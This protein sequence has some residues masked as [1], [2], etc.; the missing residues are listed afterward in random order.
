MNTATISNWLQQPHNLTEQTEEELKVLLEKHPWFVPAHYLQA[1]QFI[2]PFS[3]ASLNKMKL[4]RGNWMFFHQMMKTVKGQGKAPT[5]MAKPTHDEVVEVKAEHIQE[6]ELI[7]PVFTSDYF[8]HQGVVTEDDVPQTM[9][10]KEEVSTKTEDPKTLMVV[11]SFQEWL[12]FF[13][14]KST[15]EKEEEEDKKAL[16]MR[17]Q[18]E[19]LAAALQEENEEIPENVFN[20]AVS[21]LNREE[22][23]ASESLAEILVKQGKNEAAIDMYHKLSLR[24]PTK[25]S[26]FAHQIEILQKGI[27]E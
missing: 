14:Q 11:M 20:M 16:K 9:D 26:Y 4:Y 3:P 25:R 6:A 8:R 21:S 23:L 24:N 13:K 2:K 17:W 19:K 15:K 10:V 18:K 22:G 7:M 5:I 1:G 12:Q 27:N